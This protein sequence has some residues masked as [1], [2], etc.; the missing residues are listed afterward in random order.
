MAEEAKTVKVDLIWFYKD[1]V[2]KWAKSGKSLG[3][4]NSGYMV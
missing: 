3:Y 1:S 2:I 4:I